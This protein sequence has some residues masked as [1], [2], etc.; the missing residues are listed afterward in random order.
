MPFPTSIDAF[1]IRTWDRQQELQGTWGE[2]ILTPPDTMLIALPASSAATDAQRCQSTTARE[3]LV[4][5]EDQSSTKLSP[6]GGLQVAVHALTPKPPRQFQVTFLVKR[7]GMIAI[8]G[9][10]PD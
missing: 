1:R 4:A 7:P 5:A 8:F 9:A 3:E 6:S 2:G 10:S